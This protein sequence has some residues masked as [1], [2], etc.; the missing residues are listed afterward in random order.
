M[1]NLYYVL[2][3]LGVIALIAGIYLFATATAAAPHHY[4][5]IAALIAGVVLVLIGAYGAFIAKPKAA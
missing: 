1:K 4:T 2:L 5:K 3:A